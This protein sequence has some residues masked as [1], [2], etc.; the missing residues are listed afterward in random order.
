MVDRSETWVC[1]RSLAGIVGLDTAWGTDVSLLVVL[2]V[3]GR[4]LC[5]GLI[6]RPEESYQVCVCVCV[7]VSLS[8]I[9]CNNNPLHL[10]C[11]C[12]RSET[13]KEN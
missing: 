5:V 6:T 10:Q 3:S 1:G 4:D 8:V 2:C 7:C 9:R 13:K 11:A 12:R